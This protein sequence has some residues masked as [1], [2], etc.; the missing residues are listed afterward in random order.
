MIERRAA[1]RLE[2]AAERA[3]DQ[4]GGRRNIEPKEMLQIVDID[5]TF[6]LAR[7]ELVQSDGQTATYPPRARMSRPGRTAVALRTVTASG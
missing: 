3:S 6:Q 2:A 1:G 5:R 7:A 4:V